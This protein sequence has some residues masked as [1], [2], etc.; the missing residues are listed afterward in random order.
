MIMSCIYEYYDGQITCEDIQNE[1]S[2]IDKRQ[3]PIFSIRMFNS[4]QKERLCCKSLLSRYYN[5]NKNVV[6]CTKI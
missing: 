4:L 1:S 3:S 2:G 6:N 5:A